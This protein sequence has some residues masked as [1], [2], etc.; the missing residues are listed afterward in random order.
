[1][2]YK[3]GEQTIIVDPK[4]PIVAFQPGAQT[5]SS[6]AR[7]SSPAPKKED[8]SIDA[9]VLVGGTDKSHPCSSLANAA[10]RIAR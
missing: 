6:P 5:D 7:R 9:G 8:R 2:T 4:T 1:V 10:R 3:G